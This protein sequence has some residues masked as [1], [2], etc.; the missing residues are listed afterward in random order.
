MGAQ[1]C[2]PVEYLPLEEARS[3]FKKTA[4]D[5]MEEN[6]ELRP[7]AIQVVEECEGLPIAIVTIAKA[8]KDETVAVWKNALEQLRSCAPT[9]IRAVDKKVYSCLEWSYTH[10]KGDDVK[11]L[12]LLC[13]MLSYGDIS[14]D[15]LLRYGM[16]LDLFDRI[17]SLE[18]ARNRL[19][20][21]SVVREVARAIASKDPHPFVVREDVGLEEWSETDESKRCAF[22]SLHCKAV[23]DLP[24]ELVWP[25]LQFFLLQNNNPLLNIPNT[26]FEGMKKLKVLDLSRMHFTTLPSSLDSLANLRTLRLDGCKLGDIALIGKLTK[27]EVLSLMGSTIQQLPN[28]M[29]R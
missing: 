12:F 2:F 14:L 24:Q 25:E 23:H 22:I 9:N 19:L 16:G 6:L 15:L 1:I 20:A 8:L 3:L 28:E 13:G 29:S 10:L 17:D 27:L 26:F 4:G 5:S 7:I 11:S 18:R 21:L